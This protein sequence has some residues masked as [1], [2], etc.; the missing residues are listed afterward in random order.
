MAPRDWQSTVDEFSRIQK[1]V[2]LL[3]RMQDDVHGAAIQSELFKQK[4]LAYT[5]ELTSQAAAIGCVGRK[6]VASPAILSE[7]LEEAKTEASGIINTYNY[8]LALAIRN[9]KATAPKANRYTYAKRL[10]EW[11]DNRNEW[12]SKQIMLWNTVKWQDRAVADFLVNNPQLRGTARVE[13]QN[14]AVCDVCREW[15][16]KGNVPIEQTKQTTWPAHLN[17]PHRWVIN[18]KTGK[19]DCATLWVGTTIEEWF[20]AVDTGWR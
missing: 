16:G 9:I 6:G 18:Y 3:H 14:T 12:K 2:H 20:N 1:V 17:C 7:M 15:V 10:G 5:D 13:P 8:D 19:V 11:E 4:R